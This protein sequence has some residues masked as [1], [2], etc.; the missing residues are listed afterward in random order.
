MPEKVSPSNYNNL[1]VYCHPYVYLI[2]SEDT[3]QLNM[4]SAMAE[5]VIYRNKALES[6]ERRDKLKMDAEKSHIK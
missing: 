5:N 4:E 3:D 1:N 6:R 2:S